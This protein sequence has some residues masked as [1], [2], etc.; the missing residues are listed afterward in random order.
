M[1]ECSAVVTLFE[2]QIV[3]CAVTTHSTV[4]WATLWW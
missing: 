2:H 4:T 1:E 3:I